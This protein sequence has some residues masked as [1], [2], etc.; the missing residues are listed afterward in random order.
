MTSDFLG[1]DGILM[2][3]DESWDQVKNDPQVKA[4]IADRGEFQAR[5]A[6]AILDIASDRWYVSERCRKDFEKAGQIV[7]KNS[8]GRLKSLIMT[9]W[10]PIHRN[11]GE[12]SLNVLRMN[13]GVG[14]KQ[15][16]MRDGYFIQNGVKVFYSFNKKNHYSF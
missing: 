3:N 13:V 1:K 16:L 4:E 7:R 15:P 11:K 2:W 12:D 5:K 6:G 10:S 8:N 14:G 9:D